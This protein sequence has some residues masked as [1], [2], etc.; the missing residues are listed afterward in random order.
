MTRRTTIIVLLGAVALLAQ[1]TPASAQSCALAAEARVTTATILPGQPI[2]VGMRLLNTSN[3]TVSVDKPTE[4]GG[5]VTASVAH[6]SAPGHYRQYRGP[7]WGLD[8]N[9][10]AAPIQ[11]AAAAGVRV[12]LRLLHHAWRGAD[13]ETSVV[14]PYAF[15]LPGTYSLKL[16]FEDESACPEPG[17][18]VVVSVRVLAPQG[19]D[20]AVWNELKDCFHCALLLHKER[21]NA[22]NAAQVV[23]LAKLRDL[24]ARYP[25][26]RYAG[27]L[28]KALEVID[29]R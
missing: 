1:R 28:R 11:L 21:V 9:L 10:G 26:S 5:N 4:L 8:C 13:P 14:G 12:R 15:S 22:N 25:T 23:A 29:G 7:G 20:L 19:D 6:E 2:E 27:M 3:A 17:V 16:D 24:L 18:S